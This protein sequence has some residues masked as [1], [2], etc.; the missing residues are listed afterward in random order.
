MSN[1]GLVV[2]EFLRP[3]GT[4]EP[5]IYD[6]PDDVAEK[7]EKLNTQGYSLCVDV[8]N[9]GC[10]AYIYD[11]ICDLPIATR[12]FNHLSTANYEAAKLVREFDLAKYS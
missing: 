1:I 8:Y 6:V 3:E 7:M 4:H 10:K 2:T 11:A 9:F 5:K 12:R